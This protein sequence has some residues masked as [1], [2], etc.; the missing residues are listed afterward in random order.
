MTPGESFMTFRKFHRLALTGAASAL[1]LSVAAPP[2]AAQE[3]VSFD[4]ERQPLARALL[5]FSEQS[6]LTVAA[7]S[8][9]V[10]GKIAPA[11]EGG[12]KPTEAL[13][14]LLA[15]SGLKLNALPNGALTIAVAEDERRPLVSRVQLS[16]S[17]AGPTAPTRQ[18]QGAE[19][20]AVSPATVQEA[21]TDTVDTEQRQETIVVTGTNIRGVVPASAPVISFGVAD[22]QSTGVVTVE[23]FFA[24]L[25]QNF[26]GRSGE[27][28]GAT[29][30]ASFRTSPDLRGLGDGATLVLLNGRRM[31]A[32]GGSTPDLSFLPL[33]ALERVDVLTD[34]ASAIYG[35][36]AIAGVI[37]FVLNEKL[38][39][40]TTDI[41]YGAVGDGDHA[42]W[43]FG[44]TG[45][46]NW[47]SGSVV[48]AYSYNEQSQLDASDRDFAAAAAPFELIPDT[49]AHSGVLLLRQ[50]LGPRAGLF[51]DALYSE[52]NAGSEL[53]Q[54]TIFTTFTDNTSQQTQLSFGGFREF[55]DTWRGELFGVVSLN[56]DQSNSL[57]TRNAAFDAR[58]EVTRDSTY[59]EVGAKADGEIVTLPAGAVRASFGAGYSEEDFGTTIA[60]TNRA[61]T[62]EVL[63]RDSYYAFGE[64]F[65]PIVSRNM[66]VPLV[67]ALE[68]NLAARF[69]DYSDLGSDTVPRV[70]L[71]WSPVTSL[72]LRGSYSESFRAPSL[73]ELGGTPFIQIFS[74]VLGGDT[75]PT[76]LILNEAGPPAGDISPESSSTVS[77]GF[78]WSPAAFSGLDVSGTFFR[79]EFDNRL[80]KPD[81]TAGFAALSN[82]AAFSE[83]FIYNPTPADVANLIGNSLIGSDSLGLNTTDPAIIAANIDA[84]VDLR[85]R[86]LLRSE[87]EGLDLTLSHAGELGSFATAASLNASYIFDAKQQ[88]TR[89]AGEITT[90]DIVTQPVDLRLRGSFG[91]S[92]D[93]W[94][95]N[96]VVT[97]VDDTEDRFAARPAEVDSWT[98]FD[99]NTSY[100]F[101]DASAAVLNGLTVALGVRNVFDTPPPTVQRAA[102]ANQGLIRPI[103]YDP[104]N[105]S[106]V[107]RF[108]Q[109]RLSKAW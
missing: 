61:T 10:N 47:S 54:A 93:A 105:T 46:F 108:F 81:P 100:T 64:T 25:P 1:V 99:F 14:R 15:G 29:P 106:P 87:V 11:V 94:T 85:S 30:G 84:L 37:N 60:V 80:G 97:Y 68:L 34:G 26:N 103:G 52:A 17:S 2:A 71:A 24:T 22:I 73:R 5:D 91:L 88:A 92:R 50:D 72:R 44:Q 98:A 38:D 62:N 57:R 90:I 86:N 66:G 65:V 96:A 21:P 89:A 19:V 77:I 58:F 41:S 3:A 104:T 43:S 35:G 53:V 33:N 79:T 4:I 32:P 7:P 75:T 28:F 45:G 76:R 12:M 27:A 59:Y 67:E 51:T 42:R 101:P 69:T 83:F 56:N 18:S 74:R 49:R 63:A 78:D 16:E 6:G 95:A 109:L 23:E 9:L 20:P 107:G 70:G 40:P 31:V 8:E 82:P 48:A 36:D 55:A 39:A 13:D 102:L